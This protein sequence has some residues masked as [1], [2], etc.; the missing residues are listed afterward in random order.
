[1]IEPRGRDAELAV[2]A[3][4]LDAA[5]A[6][7]GRLLV[8]EGCAGIGKSTLAAAAV[9]LAGD[10]G[11]TVLRARGN[12][13]DQDFSFGV[14]RQAFA[15]VQAGPAWPGLCRG[16]AAHARRALTCGTPP[17]ASTADAT[18]A[19]EHGLAALTAAL[20]ARRPTLLC[21][22]DVHWADV[23]SLRWLTGL[24][25][26]VDE[27]PLALLLVARS[28]EPARDEG[29]LGECLAG[30]P[31]TVIKLGP[32]DAALAASLVTAR[33]PA[34]GP[35]F[36]A[37][38][39]AAT[40]G[41]PFLLT[42][43]IGHL[44]AAGAPVGDDAAPELGAVGPQEVAR[45]LAQRLRRLPDG[46][47]SLAHALAVLGPET[48][49]HDAAELAGLDPACAAMAADTLRTAGIVL[50]HPGTA[51][52]RPSTPAPL[53]T[54]AAEG[55]S[56]SADP[57]WP[58]PGRL[59]LAHPI[60]ATALYDGLGAAE[61]G[62]RHAR[63]AALLAARG[64]DPERAAVHLLRAEPSGRSETVSLLHAAA[65]HAT[66]R[67]APETAVT[68]LRRAL[69]EPPDDPAGDAAVRLDLALALAAGRREG[70]PGL[71][72]DAVAR[73]ADPA[74]RAEAA[75]QC[76]RALALAWQNEAAIAVYD[77]APDD[78]SIPADTRARIDAERAAVASPD[79]RTKW[80][81]HD[82]VR[83]CRAA[84][85][86]LPLWR[87][88]EALEATFDARP[89]RHSLGLLEPAR[90][91]L[92]HERD[93]LLPTVAGLTLIANGDPGAARAIAEEIT[94]AARPRGWLSTMA[95]GRFLR[96]LAV[97]PA[98][99]V[100][101]AVAD[102]RAAFDFKLASNTP[103]GGVLFALNP[104]LD[105]LL[106]AGRPAEADALIAEHVPGEPPPHELT[107][108]CFLQ[109]RARLRVA[110][111]R[112]AEAV[113]D[114]CAAGERW[115]E[116][117]VRHPAIATWRADL[118]PA[119]LATGDGEGA[120][121]A[122]REHLALA[123]QAAAPGPLSAALRACAHAAPRD[124]R[125][126]ILARAVAVSQGTQ[127]RLAYAYALV[128]LGSALRRT[129]HRDA[130]RAPLRAALDLAAA[131]GAHR[132]AA[133][134]KTELHATGARPRRAAAHGPAALTDAEHQVADLAADG[135]T[136]REIALRLVVSR[137]TVET[138]LA[139]AYQKL[140]I[141]SRQ[142]LATTLR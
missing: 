119:L 66:A 29:V 41:N 102:A 108:P 100:A 42:A 62:L 22:D 39:H 75:L 130:A 15:A 52:A 115:A 13:L 40:G 4:G 107:A 141:T 27:L 72:R 25:R 116:L 139:H 91:A 73:I 1:M 96:S 43:L 106:E 23:P 117:G 10:R 82:L 45:W 122:A 38:C 63:A 95:H 36:A 11:M 44:G 16:P 68:F 69:A 135:L 5:A 113:A 76:G 61:R 138:H 50:E 2:L 123:E 6:G 83:R 24:A 34:A 132:L 32:L 103:L 17:P 35:R 121:R 111:D 28:G 104:L 87:V 53:S 18:Y 21:V 89:A 109:S 30:A 47:T 105:A 78:A 86:P 80:L 84:P 60:V 124:R 128:D 65:S 64:G 46:C 131:G 20:A 79:S 101:E 9:R 98:G 77:L 134:A 126:E 37:A 70:A 133:R 74:A 142:D 49:L 125:V 57:S 110:Q 12:P 8:V 51:F 127:D 118:V 136:N 94:D 58:A 140:G 3:G 33:L 54:P 81:T 19:A 67:G 90:A 88:V 71:A 56:R 31:G 120:E 114:L 7:S 97:L 55:T 93:S 92:G 129:N 14:A 112:P 48:R 26:R 99:L 59:S 137:R 85:P